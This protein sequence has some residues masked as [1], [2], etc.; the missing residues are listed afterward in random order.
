MLITSSQKIVG[1]ET[2]FYQPLVQ[3]LHYLLERQ[4]I[5]VLREWLHFTSF[6]F[7]QIEETAFVR[8]PTPSCRSRIGCIWNKRRDIFWSKRTCEIHLNLPKRKRRGP[9][10]PTDMWLKSENLQM[11]ESVKREERG[12]RLYSYSFY[13]FC[14]K[15]YVYGYLFIYFC[16]QQLAQAGCS[17]CC[18]YH[19]K[20]VV[21]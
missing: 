16:F 15:Y 5:L 14:A 17:Y 20:R 2:K 18:H 1:I 21:L 9:A 19:N 12:F 3:D 7:F 8:E 10:R 11:G 13:L 4:I 6:V